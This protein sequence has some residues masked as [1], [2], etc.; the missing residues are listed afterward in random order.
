MFNVKSKFE[1]NDGGTKTVVQFQNE[2]DYQ[3]ALADY[4]AKN[5]VQIDEKPDKKALNSVLSKIKAAKGRIYLDTDEREVLA[6]HRKQFASGFI[7]EGILSEDE[8]CDGVILGDGKGNIIST[9][10]STRAKS[11]SNDAIVV[12][13]EKTDKKGKPIEAWL[14][15]LNG[16]DT[17]IYSEGQTV[18]ITAHKPDGGTALLFA[19]A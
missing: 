8:T 11:G 16:M 10:K 12:R 6:E 19:F 2:A 18:T 14:A 4:G 17:D 3:K 7:A 9:G 13:L 1:V 5:V 15:V